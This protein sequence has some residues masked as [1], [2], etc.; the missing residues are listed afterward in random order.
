MSKYRYQLSDYHAVGKAD[1]LLDG[2][3]VLAGENGSGKS[4]L[5]RW[6][7]YLVNGSRRYEECVFKE[8]EMNLQ[9]ALGPMSITSREILQRMPLEKFPSEFDF[10]SIKRPS[11]WLSKK[12]DIE[13][14]YESHVHR[15]TD[16]YIKATKHYAVILEKFLKDKTVSKD[17]QKRVLDQLGLEDYWLD[18]S[19]KV[20]ADTYTKRALQELDTYTEQLRA[21]LN[22]RQLDV[23]KRAFLSLFGEEDTM[24]Q[25]I[26][27]FEDGV[28]L[29]SG[30]ML[31]E[32]YNLNRA[33][34]IDT[35][36]ALSNS[37]SYSRFWS[38]LNE[39][40]LE[41]G[42]SVGTTEK[43]LIRRIEK[44][45]HGRTK[46]IEK[47]S[48]ISNGAELHYVD[49]DSKIEIEVEKTA[50]GFKTFIYLQ[51]L[52]ENGYLTKNAIV[53]IDEPEVHL[54]PQ[55]IVE[56]ARLLVLLNKSLGV[57]FMLA[58]H[59]PD[60]VAAIRAIAEQEGTLAQT[61]F[62]LAERDNM[63]TRYVYKNLGTEIGKIF[64]SFNIALD[65]I[66][67]Y[68]SNSL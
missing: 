48:L 19:P 49:S 5:S 12:Q 63:T 45:L 1:I 59:N 44:L 67:Q 31:Y 50:T 25:Q 27:L 8:F 30:N 28:A 4:T 36:L 32:L 20:V 65:R 66:Q 9:S 56:Y 57:K 24:P 34:Y 62:Y 6:L 33:I 21:A 47:F 41:E 58:S 53:L 60:M 64:S 26:Q 55:W 14:D 17:R 51:R 7:Y 46:R 68:G 43:K 42:E 3:T 40:V 13:T 22:K 18:R 2:I 52:L 15:M 11:L 29:L 39:L 61:H 38:E 16:F 10:S 37:S 23:L 35:P 54:H